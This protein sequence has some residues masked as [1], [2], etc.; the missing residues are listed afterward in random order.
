MR[1]NLIQAAKPPAI[2]NPVEPPPSAR[3]SYNAA[4]E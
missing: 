4:G 1:P 3:W 2:A